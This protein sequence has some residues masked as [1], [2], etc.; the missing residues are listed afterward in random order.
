[1]TKTHFETDIK[2]WKTDFWIDQF[3]KHLAFDIDK[4]SRLKTDFQIDERLKSTY[5]LISA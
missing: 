5:E 4:F 3:S 2:W 1:M